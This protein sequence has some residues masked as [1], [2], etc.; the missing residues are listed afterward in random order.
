[1]AYPINKSLFSLLFVF[2]IVRTVNPVLAQQ[3]PIADKIKE[4]IVHH[5]HTRI[6]NYNWMVEGNP[7]V[8]E[9]L[10]AENQY[11]KQVLKPTEKLQ[12][13]LYN[14]M[15]GRISQTNVSVPY[16]DNGYYYYKRN[17]EGKEYPIYLRKKDVDQAEEEIILNINELAA[18]HNYFKI[19]TFLLSISPDNKLMAFGYDTVGSTYTLRFKNL[20]TGKWL[21]DE[22]PNTT[23]DPVWANDNKTVFYSIPDSSGISNKVKRHYLGESYTKDKVVFHEKDQKFDMF[24]FKS[25]SKKYIII[26]SL[27][28]LSI[29]NLVLNADNPSEEF[30]VFQ[31]R[32]EGLEYYI[33]HYGNKFYIRTNYNAVNFR[34][35]ETL[36]NTTGKEN[37]KEVI[38]HRPDILVFNF[39]VFKNY[40]AVD[41]MKK[42]LREI[43]IFDL[44]NSTSNYIEFGEDVY[45][46][47]VVKLTGVFSTHF[48]F[49]SDWLRYAYSS[50]TTPKGIYE[51][52]MRTGERRTLKQSEVLDSY[53]PSAY[54]SKR[55]YA[56]AADNK[57]V[58]ISLVYKKG[59]VLNGENP[60]LLNAYGAYGDY[61]NVNMSA[62][63]VS[64]LDRGFVY[65]IA[66]VRGNA[67]LGREWYE[68]GKLLNKK[69]TFTDFITCAEH[70]INER[71]TKPQKI[72]A[73]GG[74]MGGLLMGAVANMRPDLFKGII[75]N[76]PVVDLATSMFDESMIYEYDEL[77]DPNIK[78]Y[79]DYMLSYSPY[80]NVQAKAYPSMLV[81]TGFYDFYWEAS[82]WV[83]KL[84]ELKTDSNSLLLYTNMS[85]DH[86][87]ASGRLEKYKQTAMEYAFLLQLSGITE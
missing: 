58:P 72:F 48:D 32:E 80:D 47:D 11:L 13:I 59:M 25:K 67:E 7:K 50:L 81:T 66:H 70:L 10:E 4:E 14:E 73:Q 65:A 56:I 46:A 85:G 68:D 33:R 37:W 44:K 64:L 38:P 49:E 83:A 42:G 41:E 60:L 78:E 52:N 77:G 54:E 21:E 53:D 86:Y 20:N 63:R 62:K 22:I 79:Y 57:K 45:T 9:H 27:S 3:A 34:V 69:N 5:N 28:S 74:S 40:L 16:K 76:V 19:S 23:G 31:P 2:A 51:Y 6:D 15:V 84:R 55:L 30:N 24:V 12:E 87:G 75:A 35:M 18:G 71:Y 8:I 82:K 29:E 26:R 61:E 17:E 1:M 36:E 43:N 39:E